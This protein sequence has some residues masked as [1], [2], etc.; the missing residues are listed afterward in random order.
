MAETFGG[1]T[2]EPKE[3]QPFSGLNFLLMIACV[4]LIVIG[5]L[6][7]TGAPTTVS[8]FNPDIFSTRRIIVGPGIAFA[9]FVLMCF[10]IVFRKSSRS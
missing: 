6:L 10:A 8:E 4:A 1:L 7:M 9:G 3:R 5:F 2:R